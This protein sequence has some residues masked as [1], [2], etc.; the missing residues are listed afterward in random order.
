M[1]VFNI[2]FCCFITTFFAARCY[3]SAALAVMRCPSVCVTFVHSVKTNKDI[4]KFFFHHW[5]ATPFLFSP[6]KRYWQYS[7]D[8]DGDPPPNGKVVCRWGGQKS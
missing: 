3:A 7:D 8:G 4:F 2:N 5:V 1:E 6:T